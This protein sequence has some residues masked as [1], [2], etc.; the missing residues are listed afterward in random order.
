ML[1]DKHDLADSRK[2]TRDV[3]RFRGGP[4]NGDWLIPFVRGERVLRIVDGQE[5][6]GRKVEQGFRELFGHEVDVPPVGVVLAVLNHRKVD[7]R[8]T[9]PDF[10][11]VSSVTAVAAEENFPSKGFQH[12]GTPERLVA[13]KGT[14]R[15]MLRGQAMEGETAR[16]RNVVLPVELNQF[17]RSET[18][19]FQMCADTQPA[20]DFRDSWLEFRDC[21]AVQVIP[22]VVRD[23]EAINI[24]HILGKIDFGPRKRFVENGKRRGGIKTG[25]TKIRWPSS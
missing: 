13:G 15:E 20:N 24:W 22:V 19:P 10:F 7:S 14:A 23:D 4:R 11:E 17:F 18:P 16:Q 25:S 3:R 1:P 2:E 12:E 21:P 6:F 9:L 8:E 5:S